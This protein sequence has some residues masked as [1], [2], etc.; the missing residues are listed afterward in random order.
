MRPPIRLKNGAAPLPIPQRMIVRPRMDFELS[1]AFRPPVAQKLMRPP[2]F[3]ISATPN[4]HS[5]HMGHLQGTVH[6]SAA[7]PF[8]RQQNPIGM[9][10]E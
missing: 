5:L 4:T 10:V 6:P 9:V 7:R 2:A 1:G 8:R 3:K